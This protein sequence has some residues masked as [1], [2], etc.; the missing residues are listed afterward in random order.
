MNYKSSFRLATPLVLLGMLFTLWGSGMPVRAAYATLPPGVWT[1]DVIDNA[2]NVGEFTSLELDATGYPHISYYDHTNGDLKYA[3][4]DASGWHTE[5]VDSM[6]DIG[7]YTSLELDSSGNPHISYQDV[8]NR[9]LKYAYR[10]QRQW[11]ID[12][13]DVGGVYGTSLALDGNNK[14]HIGYFKSSTNNSFVGDL[15]YASRSGKSWSIKLVD[16]TI[17][18]TFPCSA[19]GCGWVSIALD[20]TGLPTFT[21]AKM[22]QYSYRGINMSNSRLRLARAQPENR[23][24]SA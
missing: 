22:V 12:V 9:S 6:G 2:G 24:V 8:S 5:T 20:A 4:Q 3:Y 1:M 19:E 7:Q 17:G 11:K 18:G 23:G 14:P 16:S 13:V 21:Y 10:N 15:K